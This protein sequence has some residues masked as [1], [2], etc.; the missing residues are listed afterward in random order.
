MIYLA[1][2]LDFVLREE[3]LEVRRVE[4]ASGLHATSASHGAG[5]PRRG[6]AERDIHVRYSV[7]LGFGRLATGLDAGERF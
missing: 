5:F 3:I 1:T 2:H 7:F 6:G 4:E